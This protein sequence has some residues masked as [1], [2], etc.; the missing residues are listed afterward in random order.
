MSRLWRRS[1]VRRRVPRESQERAGLE[2]I[3]AA[4][5]AVVAATCLLSVDFNR[6]APFAH[7][8]TVH[9][10]LFAY[11][12]YAASV[13]VLLR[14]RPAAVLRLRAV[15]H[16]LDLLWAASLTSMT[17]GPSSRFSPPLYVFALLAA[18]YRWGFLETV[19]TG[20]ASVVLLAG[21]AVATA[22]GLLGIPLQV[23]DLIMGG[24]WLL[25]VAIILASLAQ[26]NERLRAELALLARIGRHTR[27]QTG[28]RASV[29]A[30]L[31]E[32]GRAF[33][34]ERALLVTEE[35]STGRAFLWSTDG[36]TAPI[37][38][39]D[40][41]VE[42]NP[43]QRNDYLFPV[44][45]EAGAWGAVGGT[46][47]G[48]PLI[49]AVDSSGRRV[50]ASFPIPDQIAGGIPWRSV[51]S[52]TAAPVEEWGAR[53]LLINPAVD[54][55]Q[56]RQ[57]R[58]LQTIVRQA[59]P[60]LV[61]IYLVRRLRAKVEEIERARVARELHDGVIQSLI[62]LEIEMDVARQHAE[63]EPRKV[64]PALERLQRLL[65]DQIV[66]VRTLMQR[67]RPVQVDGRTLV[68]SLA[69]IVARFG[70]TSDMEAS[71]VSGA[72]EVDLPPRVCRELIR[73]V[74]EAMVNAR[75]HS[76]AT[77]VTVTLGSLDGS[78]RL[79]V[80]DNG[81]G[82]DFQGR[83]SQAELK[84]RGA[85]P[86]VIMERV[87][88]IGGRLWIQSTPGKGAQLDIRVQGRENG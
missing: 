23:G 5:R 76:G 87:Q 13:V 58:F 11:I 39:A 38:E 36:P 54:A 63:R 32:L 47:A 27:V 67:L 7:T 41:P 85:G 62:G 4:A 78:W 83:L 72:N 70:R 56:D 37:D 28:L 57:L 81:R 15:V 43:A 59:G 31:D 61:N 69:D 65:R 12:L 17:G 48:R 19:M 66:D 1:G 77:Q 50:A 21:Q 26:W 68:G 22:R 88:S 45:V 8:N 75:K 33:G 10:F 80:E 42:I 79:V 40:G 71:F 86:A 25:V 52:M 6:P 55:T 73:I 30:V 18:A 44:P 20:V 35:S 51:V 82:F 49:R 2:R 14:Y 24:V 9:V 84:A 16:A 64:A 46:R 60:A 3:I 53:L 34:A 29:R 74:E